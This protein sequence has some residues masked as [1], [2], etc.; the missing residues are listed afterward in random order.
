MNRKITPTQATEIR[1]LVRVQGLKLREA[2]EQ[3]PQISL[4]QVHRIANGTSWG[5][6]TGSPAQESNSSPQKVNR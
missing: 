3:F 5:R 2:N 4:A 6:V 1:H